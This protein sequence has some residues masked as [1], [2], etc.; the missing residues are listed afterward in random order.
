[1]VGVGLGRA[2]VGRA[3]C[4]ARRRAVL[5]E[6]G[7]L[8]EVVVVLLKTGLSCRIGT[9]LVEVV[10]REVRVAQHRDIGRAEQQRRDR[11]DIQREQHR[12][13]TLSAGAVQTLG[14]CFQLH[15]RSELELDAGERRSTTASVK[16]V[17]RPSAVQASDGLAWNVITI[18]AVVA[19][20][21][22]PSVVL[23]V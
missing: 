22:A 1:V 18:S 14:R 16:L 2:A 13:A 12:E 4:A 21:V 5:P 23:S 11:Q 15:G 20:L 19:A 9:L 3:E 17:G 8:V 7:V 10:A 6:V